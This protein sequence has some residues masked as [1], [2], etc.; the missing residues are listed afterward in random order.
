MPHCLLDVFAEV[1][2]IRA[3]SCVEPPEC[4]WSRFALPPVAG[5]NVARAV[6]RPTIGAG[7]VRKPVGQI[8][9]V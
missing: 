8:G 4:P 9:V 6:T 5:S 7:A 3:R 2:W 1:G